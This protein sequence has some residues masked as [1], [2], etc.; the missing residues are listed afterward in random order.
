MGSRDDMHGMRRLAASFGVALSEIQLNA[1]ALR[2]L[3]DVLEA[4]AP[5]SPRDTTSY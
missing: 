2:F 5:Y 3:A 1:A 4:T